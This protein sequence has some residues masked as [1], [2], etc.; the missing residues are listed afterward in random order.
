MQHLRLDFVVVAFFWP[1]DGAG[2]ILS[3]YRFFTSYIRALTFDLISCYF[4]LR[5]RAGGDEE[6]QDD[7]EDGETIADHLL[8]K[9]KPLRFLPR[10]DSRTSPFYTRRLEMF[11][12]LLFHLRHRN[13]VKHLNCAQSEISIPRI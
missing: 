10:L 13:M 3:S 5:G 1:E 12:F 7:K 9:G 8:L 4:Y 6:Q 2:F 11:F